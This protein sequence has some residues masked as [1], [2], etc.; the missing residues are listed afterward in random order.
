M[1]NI[2]FID[3]IIQLEKN[4]LTFEYIAHSPKY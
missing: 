2:P 1:I 3:E 4:I